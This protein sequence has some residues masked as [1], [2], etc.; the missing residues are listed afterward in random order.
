MLIAKGSERRND[1]TSFGSTTDIGDSVHSLI[2][3]V[4]SVELDDDYEKCSD[5]VAVYRI[6]S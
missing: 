6:D 1:D 4:P 5:I 3:Y 2:A